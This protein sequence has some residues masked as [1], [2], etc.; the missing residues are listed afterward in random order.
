MKKHVI[1]VLAVGALTLGVRPGSAREL[2]EAWELQVSSALQAYHAGD[3]T[4]AERIMNGSF[5]GSG[6]IVSMMEKKPE[7]LV[8]IFETPN[9]KLDFESFFLRATDLVKELL[10]ETRLNPS[11]YFDTMAAQYS[12]EFTK[13]RAALK[14]QKVPP[15]METALGATHPSLSLLKESLER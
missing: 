6:V 4:A 10:G 2:P 1:A 5:G 3:F 12:G 8:P 9:K 13:L 14:D 7:Q 15:V 11:S